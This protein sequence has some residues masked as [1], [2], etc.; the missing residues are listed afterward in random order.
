MVEMG[1]RAKQ[2][3]IC[4]KAQECERHKK[5]IFMELQEVQED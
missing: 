2:I 3:S 1:I 4:S 5:S